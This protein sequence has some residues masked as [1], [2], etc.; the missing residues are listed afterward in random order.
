MDLLGI[1]C[2][3]GVTFYFTKVSVHTI[4]IL[5]ECFIES[6]YSPNRP[7]LPPEPITPAVHHPL[8][9]ATSSQVPAVNLTNVLATIAEES[10]TATAPDGTEENDGGAQPTAKS[11]LGKRKQDK[12]V[13]APTRQS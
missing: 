6:F 12:P 7:L 8:T 1:Q 13:S 11:R 10:N 2:N 5:F 4:Y 3:V 9:S